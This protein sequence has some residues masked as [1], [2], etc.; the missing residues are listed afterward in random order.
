MKVDKQLLNP[1]DF[2]GL[3]VFDYTADKQMSSSLAEINVAPGINHK[4]A[5][6]RR[7]DK[8][9]Y[10]VTGRIQFTV[11][12]ESYDLS[13]GDVCIIR[14]GQRFSYVNLSD[15]PAKLILIHTPNFDIESEVF[16]E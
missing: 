14:Q 9:Y 15:K 7:S 10:I 12:K 2:E 11:D 4:K 8:Y 1:I 6:S 13:E 5:W 3:K 16:E